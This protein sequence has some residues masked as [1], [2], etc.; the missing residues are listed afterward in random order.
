MKNRLFLY[1]TTLML[2]FNLAA[3]PQWQKDYHNVASVYTYG[4]N[5]VLA[6]YLEGIS[7]E[8]QKSYF[9]ITPSQV[10]NANQQISM[11]LMAKASGKKLRF[12]IDSDID[13]AHCYVTGVWLE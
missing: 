13:D 7:C 1:L 10:A 11:V 12:Q 3:E 8:N 6:V 4:A 5:G 9:L 2:S